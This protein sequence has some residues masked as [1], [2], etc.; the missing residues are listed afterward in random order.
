M[1]TQIIINAQNFHSLFDL[2]TAFKCP[3]KALKNGEDGICPLQLDSC[4]EVF[5]E[6]IVQ[7][8]AL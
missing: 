2:E 4:S 7:S 5:L 1:R 8:V 6:L 3:E